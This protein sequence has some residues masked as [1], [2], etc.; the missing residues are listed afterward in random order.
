MKT[1]FFLPVAA[2]ISI[3]LCQDAG[4]A[5]DK[6]VQAQILKIEHSWAAAEVKNDLAAID[7][8]EADDFIIIDPTGKISTKAEDMANMK[9]GDLKFE[10]MDLKESK[11]RLYGEIAIVTGRSNVKG[12]FKDQDISGTYSFTDVFAKVEGQW[13]AVSSHITRVM[14]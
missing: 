1:L 10:S 4:A 2:A 5:I 9:S 3:F 6:D 12:K 7:K 14:E 13:R 8:I 11:V